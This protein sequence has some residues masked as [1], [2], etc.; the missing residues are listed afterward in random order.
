MIF[1]FPC[2][3]L[4]TELNGIVNIRRETFWYPYFYLVAF[5]VVVFLLFLSDSLEMRK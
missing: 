2:F 1:S 5:D 4:W 3:V